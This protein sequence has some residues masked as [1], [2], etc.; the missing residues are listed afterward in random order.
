[1]TIK[2][3]AVAD[4][5]E[6]SGI[7]TFEYKVLTSKAIAE[8]RAMQTETTVETSGIVTTVLG[9]TV[10]IQDE[11]AGIV[12]YGSGLGLE[13][14]DEVKVIGSLTEYASLLEINVTKDDVTVLGKKAVPTASLVTADQL[15]EEKEECSYL[16]KR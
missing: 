12:L 4:G 15:Q 2:T 14:G 13:E 1:M 9:S 11:T 16:L 8:I 3:L 10:Y 7:S 5:L 6:N